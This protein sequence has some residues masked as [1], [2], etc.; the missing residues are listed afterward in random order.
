M[1]R[2]TTSSEDDSDVSLKSRL[3]VFEEVVTCWPRWYT[4][5]SSFT[6]MSRMIR[7]WKD[8]E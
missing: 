3:Q 8:T 4:E 6:L 2:Y 7:W 1:K 5:T